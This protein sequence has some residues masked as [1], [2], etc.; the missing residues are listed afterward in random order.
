MIQIAKMKI[1]PKV[2]LKVGL[3]VALASDLHREFYKN[4]KEFLKFF[5]TSQLGAADVCILAG[6]IGYPLLQRT[7][8]ENPFTISLSW[9]HLLKLFKQQYKHVLFVPGNHEYYQ[10]VEFKA[11]I[12]AVDRL[13]KQAC[14]KHNITFLNCD[15]WKHDDFPGVEFFGCTLWS[16][17]SAETWLKMNDNRAFST[18]AEYVE[19]NK[20][21]THWLRQALASSEAKVKYVISHHLPSATINHPQYKDSTIQ[22][23][24][25]NHLDDLFS[26]R[27]VN[28]WF[29]GHTHEK[30]YRQ[31]HGIPVY[32][33]PFGY[34]YESR[35]TTYDYKAIDLGREFEPSSDGSPP[36]V[37]AELSAEKKLQLQAAYQ[38]FIKKRQNRSDKTPTST[39][40]ENTPTS[41]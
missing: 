25:V 41:T 12:T 15:V 31:L 9:L 18:H 32:C 35:W 7:S 10:A 21:H 27:A 40:S 39:W 22:D 30:I 5:N 23:G 4:S 13:M 28:A 16:P 1:A 33:N 37:K 2:P 8:V 11:T 26:S 6:D 20:Q 17:M 19:T 14:E 24:F 34:P 3:K 29:C 38:K 36:F